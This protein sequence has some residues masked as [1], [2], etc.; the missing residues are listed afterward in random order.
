MYLCHGLRMGFPRPC[1][2]VGLR[3]GLGTLVTNS[4]KTNMAAQKKAKTTDKKRQYSDDSE[5]ELPSSPTSFNFSN[6]SINYERFIVVFYKDPSKPITQLS[7][8]TIEKTIKSI[9]GTHKS[10]KKFKDKTLLVECFS[11]QQAVNLLSHEKFFGIDVKISPHSSPNVCKG[12]IRCKELDYC[13]SLA[14]IL[15]NLEPQGVSEVKRIYIHKNKEEIPIPTNTY[16]LTFKSPSLPPIKVGYQIVKMDVYVPN[17]LRCF[18]CQQFG[19]HISKC[20]NSEVC[21]KCC[22]EGPD[23]DSDKCTNPFLCANCKSAHSSFSKECQKWKDEKEVLTIKYHNNIS[24]VEARKVLVQRKKA[25]TQSSYVGAFGTSPK[26]DECSACKIL[27]KILLQK[28]PN[29]EKE[30]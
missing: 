5:N 13:E 7:P 26:E 25:A 20:P 15:E 18:K 9:L 23:H 11:K 22:H 16:I 27:A 12:V 17:P 29:V 6:T 21:S 4:F 30:L 8:F 28:F 19:H 3:G 1:P 2:L 24:F 14:E 10:V